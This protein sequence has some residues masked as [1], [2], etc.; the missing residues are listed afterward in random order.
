MTNFDEQLKQLRQQ[1]SRK[2]HLTAMLR[3]LA[4]QHRQLQEQVAELE[5]IKL[6]EQADVDRL[7]GHSL[8]AFFYNVVGKMDE[9]LDQER[10]EAYAAAVKYDAARRD[11]EAVEQDMARCKAELTE[12]NDCEARYDKLLAEKQAALKAAGG[13]YSD[14]IYA[15]E[16]RITWLERQMDE[17]D[18]AMAAGRRALDA[19][20]SVMD[21]LR[22]AGNWG[23]WDMLGG[24]MLSDMAKHSHLDTAQRKVEQLQVEL[25]RFN[26]EL[27]DVGS[28]RADIQI[29]V[30]GFLRF[31][32][33]FF[34]NLFT[35]WAV[36]DRIRQ[37][38]N[39]VHNTIRQLQ[40]ILQRLDRMMEDNQKEWKNLHDELDALVLKAQL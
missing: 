34:D 30:D 9:K 28:V 25:R 21:S 24:G 39:Q 13:R 29:S 38:E 31:A 4:P 12:L 40:N 35:D 6:N 26:T 17:I 3:E 20:Q 8:A 19:A 10:R 11:L 2:A 1:V 27:A 14:E 32:D 15:I 33:Y 23:T 5:A 22:S 7:E 36:M 16:G 37:S 18:E